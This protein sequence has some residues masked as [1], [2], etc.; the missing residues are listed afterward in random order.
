MTLL[1]IIAAL[2]AGLFS[3]AAVHISL[4]EHPARVDCGPEVAVRE[5]RP[6]YRRAAVIGGTALRPWQGDRPR[7]SAWSA[8]T[9]RSSAAERPD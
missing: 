7:R 9:S 8:T 5:F 2:A 1:E 3:G 6:S 4:V